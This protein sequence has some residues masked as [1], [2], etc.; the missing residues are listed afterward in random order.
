MISRRKTR[1]PDP[2]NERTPPSVFTYYYPTELASTTDIQQYLLYYHN[3]KQVSLIL[4]FFNYQNV[5]VVLRLLL[6]VQYTVVSSFSSSS[7]NIHA[8]ERPLS[9]SLPRVPQQQWKGF[10]LL[11]RRRQQNQQP[12]NTRKRPRY[13]TPV[14][15]VCYKEA[16]APLCC[17]PDN[18]QIQ[19]QRVQQCGKASVFSRPHTFRI[20]KNVVTGHCVQYVCAKFAV[21]SAK[22]RGE[23]AE[24]NNPKTISRHALLALLAMKVEKG[25][26]RHE[27]KTLSLLHSALQ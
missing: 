26:K 18:T 3:F 21:R 17:G 10:L 27:N 11:C 8:L 7:S 16:T 23:E 20:A 14:C 1:Y 12:N 22:A 13:P 19:T 25:G 6:S 2:A 9:L 24:K 15:T 4:I 5:F